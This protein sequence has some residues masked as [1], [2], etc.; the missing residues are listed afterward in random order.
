[1]AEAL[2]EALAAALAAPVSDERKEALD[3]RFDEHV[4]A[5]LRK[6][7]AKQQCPFDNPPIQKCYRK[8]P[9]HFEECFHYCEGDVRTFKPDTDRFISDSYAIYAANANA[10]GGQFSIGWNTVVSSRTGDE[11]TQLAVSDFTQH[12]SLFFLLL[13]NIILNIYEYINEYI[14]KPYG[15]EFLKTIMHAIE[16]ADTTGL[17]PLN[18]ENKTDA[19]IATI[20]QQNGENDLRLGNTTIKNCIV[21]IIAKMKAT[22][23]RSRSAASGSM[24]HQTSRQ[25]RIKP[26]GGSNKKTKCT[27]RKNKISKRKTRKT[28]KRK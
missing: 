11:T 21:N 16:G 14:D 26:Y 24:R 15:E 1:M 4:Q 18:T 22:G 23:Q 19:L 10:Y 8:N 12:T 9:V 3:S 13:A 2:A 28:R 20:L 6:A 27:N 7:A 17:F 25:N 5:S